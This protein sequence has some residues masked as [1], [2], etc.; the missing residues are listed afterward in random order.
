MRMS[1]KKRSEASWV[2]SSAWEAVHIFGTLSQGRWPL[3][4][5]RRV[6]GLVPFSISFLLWRSGQKESAIRSE[7][8]W[9]KDQKRGL[10]WNHLHGRLY[11]YLAHSRREDGRVDLV[12][13]LGAYFRFNFISAVAFCR[14]I[15]ILLGRCSETF[16]LA[17]INDYC[18]I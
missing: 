5:S 9:R 8:H 10:W 13:E 1:L 2:E 4:P 16:A 15:H 17:S 14:D 11:A 18:I 3:R 12:E 7:C 6:W